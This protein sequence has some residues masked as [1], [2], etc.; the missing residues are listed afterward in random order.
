MCALRRGD[1]AVFHSML[2][3]FVLGSYWKTQVSFPVMICIRIS[4]LSLI[5][6][7][8]S[9]QNWT[10]FCFWS[11]NKILGTISAH[12]F[13]IPRSCSKIICPDSL[14]RLGSSDIIHT[15]SLQS[16]HT[17]CF[18]LV[19][20]LSVLVEGRLI[21]ELSSTSLCPF[22]KCLCHLKICFLVITSLP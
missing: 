9:S 17:S 14:F 16:L 22:S 21:L 6:S 15:V 10:W 4:R 12:I 3:L 7:S 11:F 20:F 2:Y 19:M 8:M 1:F 18:T 13:C 5:F